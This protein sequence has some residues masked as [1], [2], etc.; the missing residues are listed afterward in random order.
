[1]ARVDSWL[2]IHYFAGFYGR[3]NDVFGAVPSLHV[4]Y[5]L[6]IVLYAWPM[7][8]AL[9]RTLAL[10]FFA[11]MCFAAVYLDHHWIVD[12]LLGIVYTLAVEL[13]MRGWTRASHRNAESALVRAT[14]DS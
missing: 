9:G 1:L 14:S 6:L 10:A 8:R 13:C 2:G 12:V 3:S 4:C 7:T 5:P 11:A